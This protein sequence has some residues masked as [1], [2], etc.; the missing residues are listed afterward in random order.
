MKTDQ[1]TP[2]NID[3]YIATCSPDIR[4]VLQNLE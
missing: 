1:T 4:E 2:K 3:E